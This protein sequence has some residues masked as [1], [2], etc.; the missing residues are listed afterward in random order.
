MFTSA[1]YL[2][3]EECQGGSIVWQ[4]PLSMPLTQVKG[5]EG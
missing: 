4:T 2:L 5:A 3:F 1:D